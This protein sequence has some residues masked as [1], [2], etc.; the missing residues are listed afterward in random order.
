[1]KYF[2]SGCLLTLYLFTSGQR[3]Q[4]SYITSVYSDEFSYI[5]KDWTQNSDAS[6]VMITAEGAYRMQRMNPK[7]F[8]ISMCQRNLDLES[9][10]ITTKLKIEKNKRNK[11]A[12]GGI[13]VYGHKSGNEA[14]IIEFNNKAEYRFRV[15]QNGR[16]RVV[17]QEQNMGWMYS[18]GFKKKKENTIMVR[19]ERGIVDLHVNGK[20]ERTFIQNSSLKSGNF[21]L[22]VAS[23]SSVDFY[24]LNV[25][26]PIGYSVKKND[27]TDNTGSGDENFQDLI[28]LFKDKIDKQQQEINELKEELDI[29]QASLGMDSTLQKNLQVKENENKELALKV[30]QLEADLENKNREMEYLLTLK[31]S[32]ENEDNGDLILELTMKLTQE[33]QDNK[34][35]EAR[36][37]ELENQ[38]NSKD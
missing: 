10:E 17:F 33:R 3:I 25:K 28:L 38:L 18:K 36:I 1:M 19:G 13:V 26:V 4:T 12:S 2:I 34:K 15:L 22:F 24:N 9:F 21:G 30:R 32:L 23:Q 16:M 5:S 8:S 35:L 7:Y 29:C 11:R 27:A 31:E 37:R 14:L 20:F 6:E